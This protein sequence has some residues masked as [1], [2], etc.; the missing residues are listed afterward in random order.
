MQM[1]FMED[2]F[3][4]AYNFLANDCNEK[5]FSIIGYE[6]LKT[7]SEHGTVNRGVCE[8]DNKGN[9]VSV[10]ER[11]N[12]SQDGDKIVCNDEHLPKEL[13]IRYTCL[14]EF[15]VFSSFCF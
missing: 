3:V 9:L 12:I 4:K 7:L 8:V 14:H 2:G 15:L 11:L 5:T 10:A 1:I 13:A 6:L